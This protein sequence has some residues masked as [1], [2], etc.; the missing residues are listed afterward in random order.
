MMFTTEE[1]STE[2]ICLCVCFPF[3]RILFIIDHICEVFT[4]LYCSISEAFC[5]LII[6]LWVIL[7]SEQFYRALVG[8][9]LRCITN[10]NVIN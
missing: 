7:S 5:Y 1:I 3:K 2:Y 6:C 9:T 4:N 10:M 8:G